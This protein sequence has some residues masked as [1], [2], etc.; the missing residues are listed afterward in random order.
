MQLKF[1]QYALKL[2]TE[3]EKQFIYDIVRKKYITLGPEEWVR[4]HIL[5]YLIFDY[6]FPKS[7]ISVEKK[8]TLNELTK[9]TDILLF[10]HNSTPLLIIE[11]KAP[12]IILNPKTFEQIAGYNLT[13]RV[14]YLWITN[15]KQNILSKIDHQTSSFSFLKILPTVDELLSK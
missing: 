3:N 7:L 5:H 13:L 6:H 8:L 14:P 4:Q 12:D 10:N 1:S 2:K 11:C 9:R 15:G